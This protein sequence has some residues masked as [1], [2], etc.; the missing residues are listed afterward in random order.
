MH[1]QLMSGGL[2]SLFHSEP[3]FD[4][5]TTSPMYIEEALDQIEEAGL[6]G[7]LPMPRD[8]IMEKVDEGTNVELPPLPQFIS[9]WMREQE[10]HQGF[11]EHAESFAAYM[12]TEPH[13]LFGIAAPR[14]GS[15]GEARAAAKDLVVGENAYREWEANEGAGL[16]WSYK[17]F[18]RELGNFNADRIE[19]IEGTVEGLRILTLDDIR[20]MSDYELG[21]E[22]LRHADGEA[23]ESDDV[24]TEWGRIA[25]GFAL[26]PTQY[27]EAKLPEAASAARQQGADC[28]FRIRR[29]QTAIDGH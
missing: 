23:F 9:A 12:E 22:L 13:T 26:A 20:E 7:Q 29:E 8:K 28:D 10:A 14:S 17:Q 19:L 2:G 18:I 24:V 11:D 16:K 25:K 1:P 6:S 4:S 15:P 27:M 3:V 5:Y 21:S